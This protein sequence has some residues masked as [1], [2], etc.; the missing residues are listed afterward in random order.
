ME[1]RTKVGVLPIVQTVSAERAAG[2]RCILALSHVP[3]DACE[4]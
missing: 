2:G 3:V 4:K 1:F